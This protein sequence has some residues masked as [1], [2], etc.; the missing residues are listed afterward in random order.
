MEKSSLSRRS[1]VK[2]GIVAAASGAGL[3]LAGCSSGQASN[4][5]AAGVTASGN[6][7][8][9][10]PVEPGDTVLY[11]ATQNDYPPFTFLDTDGTLNGLDAEFVRELDARL[12]GY[13][14]EHVMSSDSGLVGVAAGRF[15]MM[16]DQM[17]VTAEREESYYF[18]EPY[19][20]AQSVIVVKKGNQEVQSLDDLAGKRVAGQ[21]G[22]S[23]SQILENYNSEHPDNPIEIVYADY[24]TVQEFEQ[25]VNEQVV[26]VVED[27]V[28]TRAY[29]KEL[30]L[31]VE[32][33]GEPVA[34]EPIA[35]VLPKNDHGLELKALLDPIIIELIEDGTITRL[36]EQWLEQDF[37]P[38][39]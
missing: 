17:A 12:A 28:M 31:E 15:D 9:G 29:I 10:A 19:F 32:I 13:T 26:A 27:P 5:E 11:N 37:T 18:S 38:R 7:P 3:A 23:Y 2:L 34:T 14:I 4:E 36:S 24:D 20:T 21:P 22:S 39:R 33:V 6:Y 16:I 1:F 30:N 35:V 8:S 25:I